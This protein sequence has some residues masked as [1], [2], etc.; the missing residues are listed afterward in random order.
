M[1][2]LISWKPFSDLDKIF[3]DTDWFLPVV[4]HPNA[5][6]PPMDVYETEND[7][8]VKM[9]IPGFDPEHIDISIENGLL[10]VSGKMEE[11]KEEKERGYI[12]KEIHT[13]SFERVI[14]LPA[15]VE[16]GDIQ[17]GYDKGI[18]KISIPK[19]KDKQNSKIKIKVN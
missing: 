11:K 3:G 18:L 17:A 2:S 13:G 4:P 12:R 10:R 15:K 19:S 8:V 6:K 1:S 16:T 7:I 9:N 5:I 14:S